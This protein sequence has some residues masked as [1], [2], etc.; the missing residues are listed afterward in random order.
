MIEIRFEVFQYISF[1]LSCSLF[2]YMVTHFVRWMIRETLPREK[3][4]RVND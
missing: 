4:K 3:M 1:I 2:F